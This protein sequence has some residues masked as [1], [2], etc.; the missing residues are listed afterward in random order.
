MSSTNPKKLPA[1][2]E[3]TLRKNPLADTPPNSL[4]S[5]V[6]NQHNTIGGKTMG[7]SIYDSFSASRTGAGVSW[8]RW[9]EPGKTVI[10]IVDDVL[11]GS[12]FNGNPCPELELS[13]VDGTVIVTAGQAQLKDAIIALRPEPGDG[14]EITYT[15]LTPLPNGRSMKTFKVKILDDLQRQA[16]HKQLEKTPDPQDTANDADAPD[17]AF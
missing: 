9:D 13:T 12:D 1:K 8:V 15:G 3:N 5:P 7:T 14:V 11:V 10:G 2:P 17:D 6:T 16:L 4:P